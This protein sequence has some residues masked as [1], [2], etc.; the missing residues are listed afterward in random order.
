MSP[1]I[2]NICERYLEKSDE[3]S[4]LDIGSKFKADGKDSYIESGKRG[5]FIARDKTKNS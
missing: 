5:M 4:L 2:Q 1:T 3:V